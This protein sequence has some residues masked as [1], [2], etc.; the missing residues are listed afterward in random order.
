[1]PSS[2]QHHPGPRQGPRQSTPKCRPRVR[3][4]ILSG[5]Q[6]TPYLTERRK[7]LHTVDDAMVCPPHGQAWTRDGGMAPMRN[8]RPLDRLGPPIPLLSAVYIKPKRVDRA[9]SNVGDGEWVYHG[10][11]W[12]SGIE[13]PGAT[14]RNLVGAGFPP[15][16][17]S[18]W[19]DPWHPH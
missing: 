6:A 8:S 4:P 9:S 18:M 16:K 2:V 7:A 11:R 5:K 12:F 1:M 19:I 15:H 10:A 17:C 14:A 3:I 13:A